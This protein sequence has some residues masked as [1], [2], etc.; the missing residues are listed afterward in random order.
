[1]FSSK[2]ENYGTYGLDLVGESFIGEALIEDMFDRV[3]E[4]NYGVEES[5]NTMGEMLNK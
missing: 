5:D 2:I 3:L 4:G 1:M